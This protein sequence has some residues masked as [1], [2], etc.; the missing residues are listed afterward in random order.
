[1]PSLRDREH[2]FSGPGDDPSRYS[3]SGHETAQL[4]VA[5]RAWPY[6]R[7][8]GTGAF[9]ENAVGQAVLDDELRARAVS[10]A[11]P[12][13]CPDVPRARIGRCR[14]PA[15]SP[16]VRRGGEVGSVGRAIGLDVHRDFCEV[17]IVEGGALRSAGRIATTPERLELFASSLARTDRVAL[18]V[19]GSAWEIARIIEPHVARVVVV[20]PADTGIRQAR[21]KTDKLDART[22]AR[23]LAAGELD[24]VWSPDQWT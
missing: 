20:S 3:D 10:V 2:R 8:S 6:G 5:V 9:T 24:G 7:S 13:T 19:T 21:A 14:S 11:A 1:M 18:E 22:L 17:A 4:R 12:A 23:L 16:F 15:R